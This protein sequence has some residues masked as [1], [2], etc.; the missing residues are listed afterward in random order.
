MIE[1]SW[2]LSEFESRVLDEKKIKML[3]QLQKSILSNAL[4]LVRPDGGEVYYSTC[5]LSQHQNEDVVL[6]CLETFKGS[7]R[8]VDAF[9]SLDPSIANELLANP[10]Y[11][12]KKGLIEGTYRFLPVSY[13]TGGLFLAKIVKSPP[14]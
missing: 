4:D 2:G 11:G 13:S 12:V 6:S 8:V 7:L 5:S 9:E 1:M 10:L 14:T 3:S